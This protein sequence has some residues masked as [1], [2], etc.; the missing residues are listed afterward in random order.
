MLSKNPV[1][2]NTFANQIT[3][4]V[5]QDS[6]HYFECYGSSDWYKNGIRIDTFDYSM[7]RRFAM[8]I[9]V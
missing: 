2:V 1:I 3:P 4:T 8:I 9:R 6:P 5:L 7:F